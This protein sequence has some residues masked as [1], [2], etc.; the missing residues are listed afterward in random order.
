MEALAK[1]SFALKFVFSKFSYVGLFAVFFLGLFFPLAIVTEFIFFEP[2]FLF[3][4]P[5]YATFDFVGILIISILT[6]LV[7]SMSIFRIRFL[8]ASTKKLRSG[9][10]GSIVGAGAGAC[11]GG[12]GFALISIFGAVGGAAT[13]FLANFE[14]PLRIAS[15]VILSFT[16]VM[17]VRDLNRECKVKP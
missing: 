1:N 3:Y 16:Y 6:G 15:I 10:L 2:S 8:Q 4:I 11:C 14:I 9:L 5:V 13:A 7:L 17:I 12:I